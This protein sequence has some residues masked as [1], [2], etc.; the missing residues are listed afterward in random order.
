MKRILLWQSG[1]STG[2]VMGRPYNYDVVRE[3]NG[4]ADRSEEKLSEAEKAARAKAA[5]ASV[6]AYRVKVF[7]LTEDDA[8]DQMAESFIGRLCLN[9]KNGERALSL[10]VP[11]YHAAMDY[12]R[13]HHSYQRAMGGRTDYE[14][15][16]DLWSL[17][18][19]P[20]PNERERKY[21][22]FCDE[23]RSKWAKRQRIIQGHVMATR[24]RLSIDFLNQCIL[25]DKEV[26]ELVPH[27]RELLNLF[28]EQQNTA[29]KK[30]A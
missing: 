13:E 23:A 30:A 26:W 22:E 7:G 20:D 16:R 15:S 4:R 29:Q 10:S 14:E 1:H 12:A 28:I 27:G 17:S 5:R 18:G 19:E 9:Y 6:T 24:S 3:P 2:A 8:R 25:Q 11:Q 21:K